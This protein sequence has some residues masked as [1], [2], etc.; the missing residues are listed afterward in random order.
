MGS[1]CFSVAGNS[2]E[3]GKS[4]DLFELIETFSAHVLR[5]GLW[6]PY[7]AVEYEWDKQEPTRVQAKNVMT[8]QRMTVNQSMSAERFD[9]FKPPVGVR[10]DDRIANRRLSSVAGSGQD[11]RLPVV[12]D[13]VSVKGRVYLDGRP[14]VHTEVET[15]TYDD[16]NESIGR[17]VSSVT[18]E[19]G[20]FEL[21][22]LVPGLKYRHHGSKDSQ[23][24]T[25]V[26]TVSTV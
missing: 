12:K 19:Q 6:I 20:Q 1:G 22:G 14:S 3:P 23:G 9:G 2:W 7:Q 11:S 17:S 10:V 18:D 25:A 4:P 16:P 13:R 5:D 15:Y 8:V 26:E 24:H 21:Y